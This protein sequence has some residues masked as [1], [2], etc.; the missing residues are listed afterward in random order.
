MAATTAKVVRFEGYVQGVGFRYTTYSMAREYSVTG[1][2]MNLPDGAV[3]LYIEGSPQQVDMFIQSVK[4][5]FSRYIQKTSV[6]EL[7]PAG[8]YTRFIVRYN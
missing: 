2:V 8:K 1:Y 7:S 4:E 5:E 3:E 6:E